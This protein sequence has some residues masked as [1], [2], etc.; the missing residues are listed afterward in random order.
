MT[1]VLHRARSHPWIAIIP[2][3]AVG[4]A[5]DPP[6]RIYVL[7]HAAAAGASQV[8]RMNLPVIEVRPVRI[9]DYLDT[10]DI[11][12]R[13]P[14][15]MIVTSRGARWGERLSVGISR[16]IAAS[17][18]YRLPRFAVTTS[19]PLDDADWTLGVDLEALDVV[20]DH[21]C[22]LMARWTLQHRR[23]GGPAASDQVTLVENGSF[24]TD[25]QVVAGIENLLTRLAERIS[26]SLI[27][28]GR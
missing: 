3:W 4:C 7:G 6:P 9:P 11:V 17:L 13:G 25:P 22:D 10:T 27:V 16:D 5:S 2:I 24:R 8:P 28:V 18:A 12:T 1:R 14:G 26:A 23:D 19:P 15:N 20:P 21:D